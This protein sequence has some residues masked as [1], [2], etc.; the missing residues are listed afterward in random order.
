MLKFAVYKCEFLKNFQTY[1]I[2]FELEKCIL[3]NISIWIILTLRCGK[4]FLNDAQKEML[5]RNLVCQFLNILNNNILYTL[6]VN[7]S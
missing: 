1:N 5:F 2:V 4:I 3:R 7:S 6:R